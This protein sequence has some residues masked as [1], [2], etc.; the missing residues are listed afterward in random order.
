MKNGSKKLV[1]DLFSFSKK[2]LNELKASGVQLSFD[3]F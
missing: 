3:I 1:P 2:T